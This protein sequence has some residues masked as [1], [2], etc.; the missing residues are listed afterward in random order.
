[1]A[2]IPLRRGIIV[3]E[4]FYT[5]QKLPHWGTINH[6]NYWLYSIIKILS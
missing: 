2:K 5:Y 6:I 3:G 4:G 1:M